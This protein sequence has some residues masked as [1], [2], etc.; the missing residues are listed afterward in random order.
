MA[1]IARLTSTMLLTVCIG[2]SLPSPAAAWCQKGTTLN[3]LNQRFPLNQGPDVVVRVDLGQL[4]QEAVNTAM[5]VNG[6]GYII[7]GAV[8]GGNGEP[9]GHT[10]QRVVVDRVYPLPFGLFG[11]SLALHDPSPSDGLPTAHITA[12]AAGP[13]LFVMDLQPWGALWRDGWW[14]GVGATCA[15]HTPKGMRSGTGWSAITTRSTTVRP[16]TM[17]EWVCWS[18]GTGIRSAAPR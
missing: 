17:M 14:K 2:L 8:N 4:V 18:R 9:Y 15:T 13:D 16:P 6:D 7:V 5:D 10:P 3:G 11:C 1:M 12:N